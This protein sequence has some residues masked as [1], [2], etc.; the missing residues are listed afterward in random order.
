MPLAFRVA[1][2]NENDRRHAIAHLNEAA[3][4]VRVETIVCDK[5]YSSRRMRDF[6]KGLGAEPVIP[7]PKNQKK[8]IRGLLRADKKFRVHDLKD[9]GDCTGL[10]AQLRG[11]L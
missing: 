3:E 7:Y 2:A 6:I 9:S 1:P 5:Q 4:K 11:E 10:K 8:G